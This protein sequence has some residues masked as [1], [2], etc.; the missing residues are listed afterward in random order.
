MCVCIFEHS[1]I[2]VCVSG[3]AVDSLAGI[4]SLR[5]EHILF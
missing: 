5:K 4:S 2:G 1:G 3:S